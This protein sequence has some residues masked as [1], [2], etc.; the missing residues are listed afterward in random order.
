MGFKIIVE[1]LGLDWLK[2]IVGIRVFKEWPPKLGQDFKIEWLDHPSDHLNDEEEIKYIEERCK[3]L[4]ESANEYI[5]V[6]EEK[7]YKL[8]NT[9]SIA[10]SLVVGFGALLLKEITQVRSYLIYPLAVVYILT[11]VS[12]LFAILISLVA[13]SVGPRYYEIMQPHSDDVLSIHKKGEVSS[14]FEHAESLYKSYKSNTLVAKRKATY[15]MGSQLWFRNA[16]YLLI[17]SA[18]FMSVT[19]ISLYRDNALDLIN[20]LVSS[21]PT[22]VASATN[23]PCPSSTATNAI[24]LMP[25]QST[26]ATLEDSEAD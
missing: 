21:T 10:A 3:L 26:T 6:I 19:S 4:N 12:F 1:R 15:L 5:N 14:R 13:V 8:L 25:T 18:I 9:L 11:A 7:A 22:A 16:I 2:E 23:T 17:L 20:P 24:D